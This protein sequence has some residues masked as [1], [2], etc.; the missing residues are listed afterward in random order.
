[1]STIVGPHVAVAAAKAAVA[2]L[3]NE[4]P[5]ARKFYQAEADN[6]THDLGFPTSNN[7]TSRLAFDLFPL[8]QAPIP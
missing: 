6:I 8:K 5:C 4:N 3:C 1:M 7:E 2:S